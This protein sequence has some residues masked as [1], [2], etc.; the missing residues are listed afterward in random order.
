MSYPLYYKLITE[1]YTFYL[2]ISK[3][4][5]IHTLSIGGKKGECVNISINTPESLLVQRGYHDLHTGTIPILA[6]NPGCALDKPL[7]KGSGTTAMIHTVLSETQKRYPYITQYTFTDNS[8]ITCDNGEGISLLS[9]SVIEHKKTWYERHFNAFLID[10]SLDKKYKAGLMILDEPELR[11]PFDAFRDIIY[12]YTTPS[13]LQHLKTYY[14]ASST[15]S[16]FFKSILDE[17]GKLGLC[18]LVASWIDAF[19][20]YIFQFNPLTASWGIPSHSIKPETILNETMLNSKPNN[21][22]GGK[23]STR[24]ILARVNI[25]DIIELS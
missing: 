11:L 12:R 2:T 21:Q 4:S 14:E 22:N 25:N 5:G 10:S 1:E 8:H 23:R 7:A 16:G 3:Q 15:Y 13:V 24:R 20:Q 19:L 9:L 17:Q 6:W 18:N